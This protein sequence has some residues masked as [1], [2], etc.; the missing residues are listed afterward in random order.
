MKARDHQS[1]H[2][3][4]QHKAACVCECVPVSVCF[5]V[6]FASWVYETSKACYFLAS[7]GS[8]SILKRLLISLLFTV[9]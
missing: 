6:D 7:T 1:S 9:I 2:F 4:T 3:P 5:R 8:L